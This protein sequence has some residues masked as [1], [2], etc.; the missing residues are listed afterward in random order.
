[1]TKAELVK[2]IAKAARENATFLD[3]SNKNIKTIPLGIAN[4]T[5][6]TTLYLYKNQITKIPEAIANLT[7]L[8]K[9][10]LSDNQITEIP[11]AIAN[12][13]NLT[14]L[15]LDFNQIT[16]IPDAI[17]N[18]TK[19]TTLYLDNNQITE[20]S[21]AI[22][23]LTNLT[24][25]YLSNNQITEIP[26]AIAN[27]TKLTS[28]DLR[29]NPIPIPV[30]I[31]NDYRNP[32]KI[33]DY[34]FRQKNEQHRSL[35]EGKLIVVGQGAVGKT[36]LVSQLIDNCWEEEGKT[37]GIKIRQWMIKARDTDV[38]LNVWD[39]GGQ[40]IM[41]ATHQFFLT[42]R[43]LYLLVLNNR[44]NER[45]NEIDRWLK[46]VQSFGKN[47]PILI[48]GNW[49]DQHPLD[50]DQ[51]G[52]QT[53]YPNIKGFFAT[54]CKDNVMG[55]TELRQAISIEIGKM[56]S[57]FVTLPQTYF[58]VKSQ[59]EQLEQQ[60]KDYIPYTD[61]QTICK[62]QKI[63]KQ[64]EQ[65]NLAQI[66]HDLGI[67]LNFADD[68]RL[69]IKD[70]YVLNPG[71]IV[72]GVYKILNDNLLMTRDRGILEIQEC[73]RIF[74]PKQDS[75]Q[76][77]YP[78]SQEHQFVIDM[79]LKFEL[80][81]HLD[82]QPAY[83][84]PDLL[85]KEEP[86]TGEWN[87]P[88]GFELH[89]EVLPQSVISRFIVK[90]HNLIS[91]K[92]CWRTG[93]VLVKDESRAYIK[94]D[95]DDGKIIIWIIGNLSTRR[96]LLSIIRNNFDA[97]HKTIA[98]LPVKE[99]VPLPDNPIVT[100]SHK[101]LLTLESI[102]ITDFVPEDTDKSYNIKELLE[103]IQTSSDRHKTERKS[104]EIIM[105]RNTIFVSYSS[106]DAE[107]L[108]EFKTHISPYE[109]A[110]NFYVWDD[111][112]IKAGDEW[113][114]EINKALAAAKVA[115]LL[116]SPNFLASKF[117]REKE[118]PPLL[119]AAKL[120]GLTIIWIPISTSSYKKTAIE[121]YQSAHPP[122]EPLDSLDKA[123]CNQAWVKICEK[124]E[125]AM[126]KSIKVEP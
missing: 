30:E 24:T 29:N 42:E 123:K 89:Y 70:T 17:A 4:L 95:L 74:T 59:I 75:D 88:L 45:A 43:S 19:L 1:M 37:Q 27:L 87:N 91:K 101:H 122:N 23:N 86:D 76:N 79:M 3:L 65:R 56:D 33:L 36:A 31:L 61:Y 118:L 98:A 78:T 119:D 5:N 13:T 102:G 52:W 67:A 57:V 113:R 69:A 46:I 54:A 55:I 16:E 44:E 99:R 11:D 10:T 12:L 97:I 26:E 73:P 116:V 105:P 106:K 117:I 63:A 49:T 15:Y 103:G 25:L 39:F 47:S 51:K 9:L 125:V 34:Y 58:N 100:V 21:E 48:V 8:T 85:T 60:G 90:S 72:G 107:I 6:L 32:Q 104:Q 115:V 120:E 110:E 35:N 82:S 94:A 77:R 114:L 92:T 2:V 50:L 111:S 20:I 41:H 96:S 93:V 38:Q 124:I 40:E 84:I 22:A 68:Y 112:K 109:W 66:L 126:K 28:L 121:K 53:K 18:L 64:N 62:Q 108:T 14:E 80:C 81:F 83:L 7:N 71:W